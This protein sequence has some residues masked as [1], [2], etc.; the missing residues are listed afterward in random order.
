VAG[1]SLLEPSFDE[2][3]HRT[4][5]VNLWHY[6][7]QPDVPVGIPAANLFGPGIGPAIGYAF[8]QDVIASG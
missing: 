1:L 5:I 2:G 7:A 6:L 8:G 3:T 4:A